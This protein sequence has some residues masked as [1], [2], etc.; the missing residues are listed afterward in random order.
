M[1]ECMS[2]AISGEMPSVLMLLDLTGAIGHLPQGG[3]TS[4]AASSSLIR[5]TFTQSMTMDLMWQVEALI[6]T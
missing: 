6:L 3:I 5:L 2:L 1:I 4:L